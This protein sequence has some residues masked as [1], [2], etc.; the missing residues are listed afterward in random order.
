MYHL[1]EFSQLIENACLEVRKANKTV[2]QID[3]IRSRH[4]VY[5]LTEFSQVIE[6]ASSELIQVDKTVLSKLTEFGHDIMC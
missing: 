5:H 3:R 1:T 4:N 6:N 2:V